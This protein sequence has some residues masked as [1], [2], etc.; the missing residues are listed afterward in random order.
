LAH[1]LAVTFPA[2][3]ACLHID[4]MSIK[5]PLVLGFMGDMPLTLLASVG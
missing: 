1:T 4:D 3:L 5:I 2:K